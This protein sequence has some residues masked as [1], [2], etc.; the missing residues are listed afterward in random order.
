MW[1]G[2]ATWLAATRIEQSR[3]GNRD[4]GP[5]RKR[6]IVAEKARTDET[7]E[8]ISRTDI[9][10]RDDI[11]RAPQELSALL[12]PGPVVAANAVT[13]MGAAHRR[14]VAAYTSGDYLGAVEQAIGDQPDGSAQRVRTPRGNPAWATRLRAPGPSQ[15]N[16]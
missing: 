11:H 15:A 9:A 8:L 5:P 4:A 3:C 7:L 1:T 16:G 12:E 13:E 14:Q 10:R 6:R 2:V